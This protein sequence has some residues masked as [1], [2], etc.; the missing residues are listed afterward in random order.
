M[1][2]Q[3]HRMDKDYKL[4]INSPT[5]EALVYKFTYLGNTLLRAVN[6]DDEVTT[7]IAKAIVA[8]DRLRGHVWNRSETRLDTKLKALR[9]LLRVQSVIS[10][11]GYYISV[12]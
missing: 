6:I 3:S 7:Q 9:K 10:V 4:L 11:N 5:F 1:N 8:F 2:Q 12:L